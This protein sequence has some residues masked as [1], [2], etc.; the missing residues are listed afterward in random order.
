MYEDMVNSAPLIFVLSTGSDPTDALLRCAAEKGYE[1]K[2]HIISWG[3]DKVL[4]PSL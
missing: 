1:D 2:L 4:S 3:K